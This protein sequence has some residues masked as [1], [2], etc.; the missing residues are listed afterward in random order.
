MHRD[1]Y[2]ATHISNFFFKAIK[3][4]IQQISSLTWVCIRK[5]ELKG[6]NLFARD[7]RGSTNLERILQSPLGF[8]SLKN[9]RTSPDYLENA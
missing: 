8:K 1:K 6:R 7:V 9:I 2:F 4:I 5:A 3:I